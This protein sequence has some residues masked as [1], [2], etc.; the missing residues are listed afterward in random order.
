MCR[1]RLA[2]RR[3]YQRLDL[4]DRDSRNDIGDLNAV[5]NN[6]FL[7]KERPVDLPSEEDEEDHEDDRDEQAEHPAAG[8]VSLRKIRLLFTQGSADQCDR[9]SLETVAEGEGKA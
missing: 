7:L 6:F 1:L 5:L 2:V 3:R 9:G 8:T 4:E